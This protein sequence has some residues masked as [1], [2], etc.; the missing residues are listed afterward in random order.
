M[1]NSSAAA[2]LIAANHLPAGINEATLFPGLHPPLSPP[3]VITQWLQMLEP[4]QESWGNVQGLAN[5]GRQQDY[6]IRASCIV[7]V[8]TSPLDSSNETAGSYI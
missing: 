2:A 5:P 6:S 1:A 8:L 7:G 4:S 3:A